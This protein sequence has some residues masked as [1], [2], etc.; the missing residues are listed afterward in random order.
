MIEAVD[1][2]IET[3]E[4]GVEV[5]LTYLTRTDGPLILIGVSDDTTLRDHFIEELTRRLPDEIT[6]RNFIF[7]RERLS[8]Y[9]GAV[10]AAESAAGRVV[11]CCTG[12][13]NLP[14]DKQSEAIKLLNA[15]R[16]RLGHTRLAVFLWLNRA[17]Y[18]EV[19]NKSYDFYSWSSHTF[20]LEPPAGW[21]KLASLRR[22][23]LNA[24]VAQNEYVNMQGLAPMRGGQIVQMRMDEIF[25]PL[26]VEEEVTLLIEENGLF[27]VNREGKLY[28]IGE[29]FESERLL[30]GSFDVDALVS[31]T[32]LPPV[33]RIVQR[34][35]RLNR[36]TKS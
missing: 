15:Q 2:G 29:G 14:R 26:R 21:D 35:G 36:E 3:F 18:V 6:L 12:L 28:E 9:E 23:Y 24:L 32:E 8:L 34:S 19:A 10:R 22:S 27:Y 4:E 25:I 17:L 5:A 1:S 31:V 13:E 33:E 30:E 20:F 16:N 11:V 7:D